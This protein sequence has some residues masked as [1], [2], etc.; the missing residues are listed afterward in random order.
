MEFQL[1]QDLDLILVPAGLFFLF[2]YHLYLLY[3]VLRHPSTTAIG[4]ENHNWMA[5]V[6]TMMQTGNA[7]AAISVISNNKSG[8]TYVAFNCFSMCGFIGLWVGSSS[9]SAYNIVFILGNTSAA[10]I[11]LK[12]MTMFFAFLLSFGGFIQSVRYYVQANSIISMPNTD[13][14]VN[15][16]QRLM[17]MGNNFW[18]IGLRLLYFA[19]VLLFW[20]FGPIPMFVSCVVMVIFL[21]FLDSN[22]EPLHQFGPVVKLPVKKVVEEV[23]VRA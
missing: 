15:Y 8:S 21:F 20:S 12:D 13:V 9:S 1:K 7:G 17:L 18:H 22:G 5:W 11:S 2:T 3:R 6:Q 16:V 14:P 4:Y 19:M 10:T 23:V